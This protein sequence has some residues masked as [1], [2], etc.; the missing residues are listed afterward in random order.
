MQQDKQNKQKTVSPFYWQQG[1]T[2]VELIC[3]IVILSILSASVL[4]RMMNMA[5]E[6][7]VAK[8][9]ALKG[10]LE[11][12]INLAKM[13]HR[14]KRSPGTINILGGSQDDLHFHADGYIDGASDGTVK[15]TA[16]SPTG[17]PCLIRATARMCKL[18]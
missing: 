7:R 14:A 16:F 11:S 9:H 1:F 12:G 13:L 8:L 6:A 2:L 5:H 10:A 15:A 18:I 4:P 17:G 3:V